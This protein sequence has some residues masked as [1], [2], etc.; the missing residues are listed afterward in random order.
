VGALLPLA[1][2]IEARVAGVARAGL[3]VRIEVVPSSDPK[4]PH[5]ATAFVTRLTS[6]QF[7]IFFADSTDASGRVRAQVM[8]GSI[9]G[10]ARLVIT[11]PEIGATDTVHY[12]VTAGNA[13][14]LQLSVRDTSVRVGGTY[15]PGASVADRFGNSRN[16][17]VTF[18]A[19]SNAASISST[20]VVTAGTTVGR[21]FVVARA[22]SFADTARFTAV[23]NVSIVAL[24]TA[25]DNKFYV[26]SSDL[27]GGNLK[28]LGATTES[29]VYPSI[30]R[31][32]GMA[33]YHES[34]DG[35]SGV[36]YIVDST[37]TRRQLVDG[38]A[39]YSAQFAR[40][41][42][43]ERFIYFNGRATS[44]APMLIWRV[45]PDGTDLTPITTPTN[46]AATQHRQA[47]SS[48]DGTQIAYSEDGMIVVR[49]LATGAK[50][51]FSGGTLPVFSPDGQK[52]AFIGSQ[53]SVAS[54][55]GG[56]IT[57]L[58]PMYID[59]SAGVAW[60]SDGQWLI[61]RSFDGVYLVNPTTSEA[62]AL[63]VLSSFFQLSLRQ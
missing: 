5:E 47:S 44:G 38:S 37:G 58:P 34:R 25:P 13:S 16:D 23:P 15:S 20:G 33:A 8:L 36:V 14:R 63:P 39:M 11:V 50:V 57:T 45:K 35:Y 26:V 55:S 41:T 54:V 53:L 24:Y 31:S 30:T 46:G 1:L 42:A 43:D 52:I 22:G 56:A 61:T 27:D 6:D 60:T 10:D 18:D 49:T 29:A 7:G 62:L 3:I 17:K 19:G 12:T 2:T 4:R 48:P 40:F 28:M 51:T 21:G 9:A 59:N 32:G